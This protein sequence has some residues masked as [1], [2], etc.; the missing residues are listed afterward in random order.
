MQFHVIPAFLTTTQFQTVS[1]PLFTLAD[2][3]NDGKFPLNITINGDEIDLSTG[4][5]NA[6]ITDTLY[7]GNQLVVYKI[8]RVLLPR[9]IFMPNS[10]PPAL[11]PREAAPAVAGP[12][13]SAEAQPV[14][15]VKSSASRVFA[16]VRIFVKG[17]AVIGVA[18]TTFLI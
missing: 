13:A 16:P 7:S 2:G 12:K 14:T 4:I 5:D 1:N 6:T 18:T 17:M 9:K 11:A 10:P 8:D 3:A 15:A